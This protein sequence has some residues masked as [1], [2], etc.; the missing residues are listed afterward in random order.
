MNS[1]QCISQDF[2][3]V[4]NEVQ[5]KLLFSYG[6]ANYENFCAQYQ[7]ID[8]QSRKIQAL[9]SALWSILIETTFHLAFAL[10]NDLPKTLFVAFLEGSLNKDTPV[11]IEARSLLCRRT[12]NIIRHIQ[13]GIGRFILLFND[14]LGLYYIKESR[15]QRICYH[16]NAESFKNL[17]KTLET[18]KQDERFKKGR[19]EHAERIK[20]LENEIKENLSRT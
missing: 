13:E 8:W 1:S 3:K 11:C 17:E 14:R 15:F 2:A 6:D 4:K 20:K 5:T 18:Q 10:F 9:P 7:P 19:E 12:F 16:L